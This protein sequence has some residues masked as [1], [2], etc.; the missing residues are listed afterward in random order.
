M[1]IIKSNLNFAGIFLILYYIDLDDY[2]ATSESLPEEIEQEEANLDK[3]NEQ[4]DDD[5]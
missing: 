2:L 1:I 5:K 4:S 3:E